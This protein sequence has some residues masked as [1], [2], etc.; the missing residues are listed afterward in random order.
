MRGTA[1]R[2]HLL[3]TE[4][5]KSH[6]RR[7]AFSP[8]SQAPWRRALSLGGGACLCFSCW[9][10]LTAAAPVLCG[11]HSNTYSYWGPPQKLLLSDPV[12]Q[13]VNFAS[14]REKYGQIPITWE[15]NDRFLTHED[16]AEFYANEGEEVHTFDTFG[17]FLVHAQN[18]Q[19]FKQNYFKM[20]DIASEDAETLEEYGLGELQPFASMVEN[21]LRRALQGTFFPPPGKLFIDQLTFSLWLGGNGS[22]TGMHVDDQSFN[23]IMVLEGVKRVVLLHPDLR[24]FTCTKP[25]STACWCG[26]DIL[27]S[28][29]AELAGK[30]IEVILHPGENIRS[31]QIRSGRIGLDQIRSDQIASSATIK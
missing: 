18:G 24:N 26:V 2:E 20:V 12:L 1:K 9:H 6:S 11:P 3:D 15:A 10:S 28:P 30:L 13:D 29:P 5:S 31:D 16:M 17:E 27:R 19:T 4:D 21:G 23:V 7:R 25:T 8:S 14:L 22:T